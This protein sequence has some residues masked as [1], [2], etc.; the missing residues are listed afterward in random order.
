MVFKNR[1]FTEEEKKGV[2]YLMDSDSIIAKFK[3]INDLKK[4]FNIDKIEKINFIDKTK[5]AMVFKTDREGHRGLA[6][7]F[8]SQLKNAGYK[9]YKS[10]YGFIIAK[11]PDVKS[12]YIVAPLTLD[13]YEP[14]AT[15]DTIFMYEVPEFEKGNVALWFESKTLSKNKQFPKYIVSVVKRGDNGVSTRIADY[16]GDVDFKEILHVGGVFSMVKQNKS[17]YMRSIKRAFNEKGIIV[18]LVSG[19]PKSSKTTKPVKVS[20]HKKKGK[21]IS[22]YR[23]RKPRPRLVGKSDRPRDKQRKALHSG[24]RTSKAGN[25]YSETRRNRADKDRRKRL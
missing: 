4:V 14:T 3:N 13:D 22:K 17:D 16:D 25:K 11:K 12:V 10:Q 8:Y 18:R 6:K 15:K 9:F 21:R 5:T 24:I 7:T 23:R 2:K 20:Q 19:K 1:K